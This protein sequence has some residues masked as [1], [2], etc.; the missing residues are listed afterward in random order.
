LPCTTAGHEYSSRLSSSVTLAKSGHLFVHRRHTRRGAG[1]GAS[2]AMA[3]GV[4]R[5]IKYTPFIFGPSIHQPSKE[6]TA[7]ASPS[8]PRCLSPPCDTPA[9]ARPLVV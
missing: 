2:R 5:K 6:Q 3:L 8:R 9:A 1:P 7:P 4:G